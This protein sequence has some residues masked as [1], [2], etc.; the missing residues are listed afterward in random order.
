MKGNNLLLDR[1][2]TC[3]LSGASALIIMVLHYMMQLPAYPSVLNVPAGS[4][5]AMFLLISGFG[6]NESYKNKGLAGYWGRRL[7]RVLI[8]YWLVILARLPFNDD[9]C[10]GQIVG[11]FLCIGSSLWFIDYIVRCYIVYWFCR[12]FAGRYTILLLSAFS[13]YSLLLPQLMSEQSI[14]FLLGVLISEHYDRIGS[15]SRRR[16][17]QIAICCMTYSIFVLALKSLPAI[18]VLKGSLLFNFMLLNIRATSALALLTVPYFFPWVKNKVMSIVG[19]ISYELYIVHINFMPFVAGSVV[20]VGCYSVYS[21][22]ISWIFQ[23]FNQLYVKCERYVLSAALLLFM[24]ISYLLITKYAMRVTPYFGYVT[25][26][27]LCALAAVVPL[28]ISRKFCILGSKRALWGILAGFVVVM[29][30]VQFYVDPMS[31]QVDRWSALHYPIQHLLHG[32][33]PYLAQTHLGGYASPF[34]MWQVFHI[35]FYLLGN[36]GLSEIVTSALFVLSVWYLYDVRRAMLAMLLLML[37]V[38]FWYE[39]AVRSDMI[40]N[41]LLLASFVNVLIKRNCTFDGRVI[42]LSAVAGLW[43]STR[44]STAFPLY[45]LFLPMWLKLSLVKKLAAPLV[46]VGV[47]VLTFLPLLLWNAPM[48]LHHPYSPLVLQTSQGT[49]LDSIVLLCVATCLALMWQRNLSR[50]YLCSGIMLTLLPLI[51]YGHMMIVAS[52]PLNIYDSWCDITYLHAS[53]PFLIMCVCSVE[54]EGKD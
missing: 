22:V 4:C 33:F 14:S 34:P 45:I 10:T 18:Q 35:P 37:T 1:E 29:F 39:V 42:L 11:D 30:A 49:P 27:Y 47:L 43:L 25:L 32:Q 24:G 17:A 48:L 40:S 15:W 52:E 23:R 3:W 20:R 19:E 5:V 44:I 12:K 50:Y 21:L 46:A 6:I 54:T 36:V 28:L 7:R 8:P 31:I 41:F 51:S 13:L 26:T 2:N 53:I 16:I 9:I 38:S